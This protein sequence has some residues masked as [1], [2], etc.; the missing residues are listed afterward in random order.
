MCLSSA[1]QKQSQKLFRLS[2]ACNIL[3]LLHISGWLGDSV[4]TG[5]LRR[6]ALVKRR[7]SKELYSLNYTATYRTEMIEIRPARLIFNRKMP[8]VLATWDLNL[9]S[10]SS[11]SLLLWEQI[12]VTNTASVLVVRAENAFNYNGM[13]HREQ[14]YPTQLLF[15]KS[16]YFA[17]LR[18][19]SF[20]GKL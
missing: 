11:K 7:L 17:L 18:V 2:M 10:K 16:I 14:S 9:T 4:V 15:K 12:R 5:F 8:L 19:S 6:T 3:C 1:Q 13:I 20:E